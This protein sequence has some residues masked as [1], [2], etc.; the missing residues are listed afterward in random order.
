MK[1]KKKV[2]EKESAKS[3]MKQKPLMKQEAVSATKEKGKEL[4]PIDT[5]GSP[6]NASSS[7]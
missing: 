4:T 2:Q 5:K 6:K 1:S 7:G 3:E